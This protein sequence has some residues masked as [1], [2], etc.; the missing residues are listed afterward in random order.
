MRKGIQDVQVA[1]TGMADRLC[2]GGDFEKLLDEKSMEHYRTTLKNIAQENVRQER[3]LQAYMTTLQ[4]LGNRN[5]DPEEDVE[6]E[7]AAPDDFQQLIETTMDQEREKMERESIDV[8]H[9]EKYLEM[10]SRLG[11]Q[12]PAGTQGSGPAG[13]G[14]DSDEDLQ[15][16][17]QGG[18]GGENL[19]CPITTMLM[20][21][22][23]RNTVCGHAYSLDAIVQ[24]LRTN[25]TCPVFGCNNKN[26]V[27]SHL[28]E[29]PDLALKIRRAKKR[30]SAEKRTMRHTPA[31]E[32]DD[33]EEED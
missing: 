11:E 9:E 1:A 3:E 31:L 17:T 26:V 27:R 25:R 21:N 33:D 30:M 20:E 22:P 7:N 18:N 4:V 24:L 10:L 2:I 15:V 29:D 19:K 28:V 32:L 5:D 23:V 8:T 6:D 16:L 13:D 12:A 14:D